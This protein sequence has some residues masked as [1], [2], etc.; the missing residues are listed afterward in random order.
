MNIQ[1]EE[2][3]RARNVGKGQGF[4]ALSRHHCPSTY[5]CSPTWKLPNPVLWGFLCRLHQVGIINQ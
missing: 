1:M 2:M 5:V 4:H 3:H